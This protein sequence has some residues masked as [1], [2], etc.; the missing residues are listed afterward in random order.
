MLRRSGF[1]LCVLCRCGVVVQRSF[2]LQEIFGGG[3]GCWDLIVCVQLLLAETH[4]TQ[5]IMVDNSTA[6]VAPAMAHA[7]AQTQQLPQPRNPSAIF[8]VSSAAFILA[9][10]LTANFWLMCTQLRNIAENNREHA[11]WAVSHS[12]TT[13][14]MR[15]RYLLQLVADGNT[16]WRSAYLSNMN[17]DG[18]NLSGVR[19]AQIR[20]SSGSFIDANFSESNLSGA[21]LDLSDFTAAKFS[22]SNLRN[23]TFFK[24]RL[25]E[26][27]F[28]NADLLSISLEQCVAAKANF[29][30]AT[31]GEAFCPM[32]DFSDA[33]LTGADLSGANLEAA[34]LQN[35]NLAL[36]NFQ[37]AKLID[38][39]FTDTNWWRAR[40]LTSVQMDDFTLLF[41]PTPNATEARQRDFA[42]WLGKRIDDRRPQETE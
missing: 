41:P 15:S 19:L 12:G 11:F 3:D 38:T 16:E 21:A 6:D 40:G 7:A 9:S 24:S 31:M 4:I 20:L 23:A 14:E 32:A 8:W 39:D 22:K 29:V 42:L 36:T 25:V 35:A 28:R 33:D 37:A 26:A 13:A 10:L 2:P 17:M 1:G 27:D 5:T 18:I 34:I 30:A